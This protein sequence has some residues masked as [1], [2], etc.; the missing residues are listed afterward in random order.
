MK[1]EFIPASKESELVVPMPK[2]AK[3]YIPQWYKNIPASSKDL[4][5]R[6][7]GDIGSQNIKSC[8]PF[9]DAYTHGYIQET[10]TDIHIQS[11]EDGS[12]VVDYNWPSGPKIVSHRDN[13][14]GFSISD[15]FY[16][17]EFLWNEQWIP[18][19]PDGYSALYTSP[20]NHF[21]LPFRS[22][23]A[24]IDSDKYH[25][26]YGGLYPFFVNKGFSGVIPAG[27]PM[28][29]IVPIKR[30][31]WSSTAEKFNSDKNR[32]RQHSLRKYFINGYKNLFWQKKSFE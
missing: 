27:T 1:I 31:N 19:L 7:P 30:D 16:S 4:S 15:L 8:A 22:L 29:Q 18:K 13:P 17:T 26:E 12:Y 14:S 24:V 6:A 9:L 28:Y 2:P 21:D 10:W 11:S 25:H 3:F 23:D 32:E 5:F 20:F